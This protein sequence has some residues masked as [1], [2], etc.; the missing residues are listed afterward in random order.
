MAEHIPKIFPSGA[1]HAVNAPFAKEHM[2]NIQIKADD[3]FLLES[4][5]NI[6]VKAGDDNVL[7]IAGVDTP[8][9]DGGHRIILVS[10][11][12]DPDEEG[13][14][15]DIAVPPRRGISLTAASSIILKAPKIVFIG[16][17][18]FKGGDV[19]VRENLKCDKIVSDSTG[20]GVIA[21]P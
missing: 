14:H 4:G 20:E 21:A 1:Q 16:E 2:D 13:D 10:G 11:Y 6:T 12:G 18:E 15:I 9:I 7:V 5:K 17:V 8:I 3:Y 19:T